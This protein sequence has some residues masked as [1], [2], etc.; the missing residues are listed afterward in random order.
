[1]GLRRVQAEET[2]V[3]NKLTPPCPEPQTVPGA[4]LNLPSIAKPRVG[5]MDVA[6]RLSFGDLRASLVGKGKGGSE[7]LMVSG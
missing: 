4:L 7:G 2:P 5:I 1:M 6:L 3:A